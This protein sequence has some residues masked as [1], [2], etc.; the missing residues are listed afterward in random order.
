MRCY[1]IF[2]TLVPFSSLL[3]QVSGSFDGAN[4]FITDGDSLTTGWVVNKAWPFRV[5]LSGFDV[6]NAASGGYGLD[7]MARL[8]FENVYPHRSNIAA[9]NI[10]VIFGGS[11]NIASGLSIEKTYGF[12]VGYANTARAQGFKVIV[13]TPVSRVGWDPQLAGYASLIRET[14]FY[15]ADEIAD[16]NADPRLGCDGCST[17]PLFPDQIHVTDDGQQMIADIVRASVDRLMKQKLSSFANVNVGGGY[18][19]RGVA[20]ATF[21][22]KIQ[23]GDGSV[24]IERVSGGLIV[25]NT[26][27][28]ELGDRSAVRPPTV[29]MLR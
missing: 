5:K 25:E 17:T 6:H 20:G 27:P 29:T 26:C 11:D 1:L 23:C 12:L 24:G 21:S 3:A 4:E 10:L 16:L 14:W 9:W 22:K 19:V 28:D 2:L 7:T 13:L 18:Y 15:F 8:A